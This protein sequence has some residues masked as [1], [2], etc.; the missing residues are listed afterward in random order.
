MMNLGFGVACTAAVCRVGSRL[1]RLVTASSGET[2]HIDG[3]VLACSLLLQHR[4]TSEQLSVV[5][6]EV[7]NPVTFSF[8][9]FRYFCLDHRQLP[10]R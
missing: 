10:H 8:S 2:V 5:C 1:L 6:I 3:Y 7:L 9:P 4:N